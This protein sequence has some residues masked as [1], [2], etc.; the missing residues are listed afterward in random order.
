MMPIQQDEY[1]KFKNALKLLA[2]IQKRRTAKVETG[3]LIDVVEATSGFAKIGEKWSLDEDAVSAYFVLKL[4]H[5]WMRANLNE[6]NDPTGFYRKTLEIIEKKFDA[7]MYAR[8]HTK[9][10]YDKVISESV[11]NIT[12][13]EQTYVTGETNESNKEE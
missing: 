12:P 2:Q 13:T 7:L 4:L 8:S 5:K 1:T 6:K 9:D 3:E 10:E 11:V